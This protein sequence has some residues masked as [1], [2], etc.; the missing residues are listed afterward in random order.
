MSFLGESVELQAEDLAQRYLWSDRV[1]ELLAVEVV[2]SLAQAGDVQWA[3]ADH[4]GTIRDVVDAD[5]NVINHRT[6]SAFGQLV[7]ETAADTLSFGYTGRYL[8]ESTGLQNNW[9]R[10]YDNEIGRWMSED[11]IGF[12]AGDANLYRYVGNEVVSE[13]DPTGLEVGDWLGPSREYS[14]CG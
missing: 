1:D 12:E 6:Y 7:H 10:W 14:G 11:P 3:L 9:N 2:D 4:L 13:L 8:D 5:G